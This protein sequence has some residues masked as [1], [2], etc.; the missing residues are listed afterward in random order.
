L[1][2]IRLSSLLGLCQE[3]PQVFQFFFFNIADHLNAMLERVE[4][5]ISLKPE[6]RVQYLINHKKEL[7]AS[8]PQKYLAD[9]IGITPVSLSR[10]LK[11]I[12]GD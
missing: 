2:E 11:K 5:L 1:I 9:Y 8:I 4:N 10:L 3:H 12:N 6:E 7:L